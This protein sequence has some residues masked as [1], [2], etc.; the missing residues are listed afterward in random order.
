M[1]KPFI[2]LFIIISSFKLTGQAYPRLEND[3]EIKFNIGQ[4]LVTSSVEASY[5]Y[6][7][8]EDTSIG[9]TIYADNDATDY[10]G[11]FGIGPNL[12][13]YFGYAPRSG[14]FAEAFGL[15]YTGED[16]FDSDDLGT[17]NNDYNTIAL[18]LGAGAKWATR[19]ER[20]TLEINGGLGRNVNPK[21]FQNMFMYRAG[22]SIGFRF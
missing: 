13:A 18:G 1:K 16:E 19:S 9:G 5:E 10:N 11:N 17:R 15:Y 7:I 21:D 2:L 3:H 6:Y 14:F 12:R 4:F 20:F 22:L 8:N